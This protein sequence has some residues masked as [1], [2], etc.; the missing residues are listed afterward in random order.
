MKHQGSN[1]NTIKAE[2]NS[3]ILNLIRRGPISRAEIC[4]LTGLSK[5]SV[6][7]ITKQLIEEGLLVEIGTEH[8]IKC[9]G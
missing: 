5:S 6:T 4:K 7:T 2:N 9:I 8:T 1:I 3:L